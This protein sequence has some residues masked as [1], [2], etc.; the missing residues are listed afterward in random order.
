MNRN[1]NARFKKQVGIGLG[2]LLLIIVLVVAIGAAAMKFSSDSTPSTSGQQAQLDAG[3]FAN[4]IGAMRGN[5]TMLATSTTAPWSSF[6]PAASPRRMALGDATG[7]ITGD[8]LNL[9]K[10]RQVAI[11]PKGESGAM[12]WRY[13]VANTDGAIYMYTDN[14]DVSAKV[15]DQFNVAATGSQAVLAQADLGAATIAT[16]TNTGAAGPTQVSAYTASGNFAVALAGM[17]NDAG[18]YREDG[19]ATKK[20]RIVARLR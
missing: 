7:A 3:T 11:P 9:D 17:T 18:C 19:T 8:L 13:T 20:G 14:A 10:N 16:A 6:G 4:Q 5:L 12:E 2:Y 1:F 15:C